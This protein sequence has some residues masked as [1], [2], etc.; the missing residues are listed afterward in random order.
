[1]G[2]GTPRLSLMDLG[3]V[4]VW[5]ARMGLGTL[6]WKD[7]TLQ[8]LL[9]VRI[10]KVIVD[11]YCVVRKRWEK[12]SGLRFLFFG[13]FQYWSMKK[14]MYRERLRLNKISRFGTFLPTISGLFFPWFLP[15][16]P[17]F[18]FIKILLSLNLENSTRSI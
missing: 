16:L 1:M 10:S 8:D 7:S 2:G 17:I 4:W 11:L 6:L 3:F 15:L 12:K 5:R 14:L 13:F 9:V 18:F